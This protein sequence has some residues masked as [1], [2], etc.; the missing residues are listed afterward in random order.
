MSSDILYFSVDDQWRAQALS[1]SPKRYLA[2]SA[3]S[4]LAS[5]I[6]KIIYDLI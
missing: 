6:G 3:R 4:V 2:P 5:S 1:K